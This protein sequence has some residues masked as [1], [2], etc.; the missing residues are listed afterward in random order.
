MSN[1][2][3]KLALELAA[4]ATG[5]EEIAELNK[6]VGNL[7]PISNAVEQ[8]TKE[9]AA[10]MQQ[11][12]QQRDQI[13][14][15]KKSKDALTQLEL[16][17]VLSRDKL[18]SLRKVQASGAGDAEQLAKQEKLLASEVKQLESQLVRQAATHTKLG[19][20]LKQSGID[21]RNLGTEQNRL[22]RE[23]TETASRTEKLAR[24]LTGSKAAAA[25]FA[26]SVG[27][28]TTRLLA[29]G[30]AYL[31]VDRLWESLKAMFASGDQAERLSVQLKAVMGS[32]KG[33][34]E[35]TAWIN[36][37]ATETP[38]QL[39]EVTQL[40]VRL[41]AFGLD[42]MDGSLQAIVDQTYKLGGGFE[43]AQGISL[44]LGQA[45]AKQKLQGEEI[46]QMIERG[47]P[48]WEMLE[49]VTGKNTAELEKLSSAG[50]L[51]R[52]TIKALMEEIGKQ[53]AGAAA[54]NMSLLSGLISN[55]KDNLEKFYRM[56]SENGSLD[57]LK[58]QL[59]TL[60]AEFAK[61]AADGS[62]QQWAK[63]I[64]DSIVS[65]GEF[66]KSFIQTCYEWSSALKTVAIAF[67]AFKFTQFIGG[68]QSAAKALVVELI[69]ALL[70]VGQV[71]SGEAA[72]GTSK[73]ATSFGLLISRANAYAL[74]IGAVVAAGYGIGEIAK[75]VFDL[76][77]GQEIK[78]RIAEQERQLN[79]QLLRQGAEL[80][81]QNAQYKDLNI[82]TADQVKY[83]SATEQAAYEQRLNGLK[84]YLVGQ[85][86]QNAALEKTGQLTEEQ[87]NKTLTAVAAMR[88]GF[89]AFEAGQQAALTQA[90]K[91]LTDY[92]SDVTAA[93]EA[94]KRLADA[95]L[96][97]VFS[98]AKLDLDQISGK[99]GKVVTE[100][101]SGLDV[102]TKASSVNAV[103][104]QGYLEKAFE[105][106][107]NKAELDALSEKM[108]LLHAQGK[109][110]GQPYI[111]SL[112][113]ATAAAKKMA[114]E[115][116]AGATAYSAALKAQ[117]AAVEEAY[118]KGE[119]GAEQHRQQVGKLNRELEKTVA[120]AK[121]NVQAADEMNQAYSDFGMQSGKQLEDVAARL[122]AS[123][124]VIQS[125]AQPLEQ[126]RQAFLKYAEAELAAAQA[127]DR[128]ANGALS[129]QAATLGLSS[130]FDALEKSVAA[131]GKEALITAG[132]LD[133][134]GASSKKAGANVATAG[135]NVDQHSDG[136]K[137]L[138]EHTREASAGQ[139]TFAD[140]MMKSSEVAS[141]SLDDIN[142]KM[143]E[144]QEIWES[145]YNYLLKS[146]DLSTEW[147]SPYVLKQKLA[148]ENNLQIL[149]QMKRVREASDALASA[150]QPTAKL[151]ANAERAVKAAYKLDDQTLSSFRAAIDSAKQ[152]MNELADSAASTVSNLRDELDQ[153]S[154]NY[155]AIERRR[156]DEQVASLQASLE[157]A[158]AAGNADAVASYK[159]A[160]R[161]AEE[162]HQKKMATIKAEQAAAAQET[163]EAKKTA[164]SNTAAKASTAAKTANQ[165]TSETTT[166]SREITINLPGSRQTIKTDAAGEA[167]LE[168]VLRQLES[169]GA[170]TP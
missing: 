50:E 114:T 152:K 51:G 26:G 82:L 136:M 16:A 85:L 12:G 44:A 7:G 81:A 42:P 151:V 127:T 138:Q 113:Q 123:F 137:K 48:V 141:M 154:E 86:Q 28:V 39:D 64:S 110:I 68:V 17:T 149:G 5:R 70:R 150:E 37:F 74:A 107:K 33:G 46:L 69:P 6:E 146:N 94:T 144:A 99:V 71:A 162:L 142:T 102:M 14:A 93:S 97:D 24:E 27:G 135:Q 41:K 133:T 111:D 21:T 156:Y 164:A 80:I 31:G 125:G 54:D 55:A 9:L 100:Y 155:D 45:W 121:K 58:Q 57:W 92:T 112:A 130:E 157:T 38:L 140:V 78:N 87:K 118:K 163:A 29:L 159:E 25:S 95:G 169:V 40:F 103:A 84:G 76:T 22:Q 117:K 143:A 139:L 148:Q 61:M 52:D 59:A 8:E 88:D 83:L 53:S 2:D 3:L 161:L 32:I 79:D 170:I 4:K 104:I 101:V 35:A 89:T 91:S 106:A 62:L 15:F 18:E 128:Y 160:L 67:A 129:A 77:E 23:I 75:A 168:S 145:S 63:K 131:T 13:D 49:K 165:N 30:A 120:A 34:A 122:K 108:A 73:L 166:L 98:K 115:S 10:R 56:V 60:N 47:V 132:A 116:V 134:L 124:Q 20:G 11:L 19:V 1:K 36:K 66:I 126:V 65:A 119:I 43:E 153:L 147:W 109:L 105:S 90:S 158:R 96:D 72:A 167:A